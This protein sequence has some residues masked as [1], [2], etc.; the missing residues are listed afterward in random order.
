MGGKQYVFV[1]V[2]EVLSQNDDITCA[3]KPNS[4]NFKQ[5]ENLKNFLV[6]LRENENESAPSEK[7]SPHRVISDLAFLIMTSGQRSCI[8]CNSVAML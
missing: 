6:K 2:K 4:F 8:V 5:F 3:R 1:S 7:M